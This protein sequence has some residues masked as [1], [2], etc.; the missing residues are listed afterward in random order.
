M[1]SLLNFSVSFILMNDS[2]QFWNIALY[3]SDPW[4]A[5][6]CQKVSLSQP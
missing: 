2:L 4:M 1:Q 6:Y 3:L 5:T